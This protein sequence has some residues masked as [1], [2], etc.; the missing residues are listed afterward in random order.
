MHMCTCVCM[1][2][3]RNRGRGGRKRDIRWG[4]RDFFLHAQNEHLQKLTVY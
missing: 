2:V 1:C 4:E 3:E